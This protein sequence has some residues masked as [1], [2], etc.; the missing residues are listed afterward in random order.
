MIIDRS[1]TIER[2]VD[3]MLD[4]LAQSNE[5]LM[6]VVMDGHVGYANMSNRALAR[7]YREQFDEDPPSIRRKA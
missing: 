4:S 5:Y 6:S 7:E 1:A 2:L 3:D